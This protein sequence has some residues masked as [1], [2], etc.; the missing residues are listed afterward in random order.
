MDVGLHM[1]LDNLT[2]WFDYVTV[3]TWYLVDTF[4]SLPS[5]SLAG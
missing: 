4:Y 1:M 5:D 3:S 2:L